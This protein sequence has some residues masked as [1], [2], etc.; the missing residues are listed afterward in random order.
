MTNLF[1][2]TLSLSNPP[3]FSCDYKA[4]LKDAP[5]GTFVVRS[6]DNSF[7]A[8]SLNAPVGLYHMHIESDRGGK[9]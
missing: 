2:V 7:A 4:K 9:N 8:L 5:I 6:S 3:A 1:I